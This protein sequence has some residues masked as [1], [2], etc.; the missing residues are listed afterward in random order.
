MIWNKASWE[1]GLYKLY[2]FFSKEARWSNTAAAHYSYAGVENQQTVVKCTTMKVFFVAHN[3]S[4]MYG[5][6]GFFLFFA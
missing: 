5:L 2:A 6:L 3:L 1:I 4:N